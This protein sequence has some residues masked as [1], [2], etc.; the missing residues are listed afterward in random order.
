MAYALAVIAGILNFIP[1]FGPLLAM[2]PAVL[3][4][5]TQSPGS[6]S[7]VAVLYV[8]VQ[9]LESNFITPQI[10]KRLIN[11]PAALIIIA[12]I[13]MGVFTGG[14]GLIVATP[15]IIIIIT[16]TEELYIKDQDI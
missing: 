4:G 9:V 16:V 1:N 3:V 8:V 12:Q 13:M 2:I 14:W 6:A 10:Q 11:I 15:L 5:L 7:L